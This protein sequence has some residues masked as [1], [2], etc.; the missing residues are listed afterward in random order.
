MELIDRRA[1]IDAADRADYRGLTVEDVRAVTDEVVKELK[2][3]P[4]IDAEP[5]RKGKWM[6]DHHTAEYFCSECGKRY[7][8]VIQEID[9]GEYRYCPNCGAKMDG[10]EE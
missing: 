2:A 1:A 9:Q 6:W 8:Y 7:E 3:L 10:G 5:V 4:T